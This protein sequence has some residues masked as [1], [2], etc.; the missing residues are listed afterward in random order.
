MGA[1]PSEHI[2]EKEKS[3]VHTRADRLPTLVFSH[4]AEL[5]NTYARELAEKARASRTGSG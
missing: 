5:L 3:F 2:V 4:T 1:E